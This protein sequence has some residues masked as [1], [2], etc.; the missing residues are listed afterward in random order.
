MAAVIIE[1][2]IRL[3]NRVSLL[4]PRLKRQRNDALTASV[5]VF[6]GNPAFLYGQHNFVVRSLGG[7]GQITA[8]RDC[9][10][11]VMDSAPI[12]YHYAAKAPFTA[13]YAVKVFFVGGGKNAA[14]FIVCG[15]NSPGAGFFYHRFK[16]RQIY[17]PHGAL[18]HFRRRIHT[19][20]FLIVGKE[21]FNTGSHSPL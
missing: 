9:G 20:V 15:H 13:Q 11:P 2:N 17:F 1:T 19:A 16:G 4:F 14:D 10:G 3:A 8:R 21:M 18:V 5:K 7:H 12:T 6:F